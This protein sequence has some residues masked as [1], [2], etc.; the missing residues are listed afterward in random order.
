MYIERERETQYYTSI[1]NILPYIITVVGGAD[2]E[3]EAERDGLVIYYYHY[4]YSSL[5][6]HL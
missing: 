4:Y 2:P 6:K 3:A 1:T 5:F